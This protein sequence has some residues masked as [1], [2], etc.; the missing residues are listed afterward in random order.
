MTA[1]HRARHN[2]LLGYPVRH[3]FP[4]ALREA[5]AFEKRL[6]IEMAASNS[7]VQAEI[8]RLRAMHTPEATA[9]RKAELHG[10]EARCGMPTRSF[11]R[12]FYL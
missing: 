9:K 1:K 3:Y 5:W 11:S 12:E 8:A 4:Q 6:R 7:R 2:C 10:W